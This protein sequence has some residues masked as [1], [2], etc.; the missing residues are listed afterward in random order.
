MG[1]LIDRFLPPVR[2]QHP[3]PDRRFHVMHSR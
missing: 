1:R 3:W 2:V